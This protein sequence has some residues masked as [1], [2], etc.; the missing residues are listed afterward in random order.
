VL[1]NTQLQGTYEPKFFGAHNLDNGLAALLAAQHC[2]VPIEIGLRGLE[3]FCGVKRRLELRGEVKNIKVY[4]DF[5][6][7]PTAIKSTIKAVKQQYPDARV[8]AVFEPRSNSMKMGH[9]N[10]S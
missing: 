10:E 5:A 1:N 8:L 4:D 7:H 3:N 9:H 6:H 2:G